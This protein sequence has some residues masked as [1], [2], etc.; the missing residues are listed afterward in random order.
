MNS[1]QLTRIYFAILLGV[2]TL[3]SNISKAQCDTIANVCQKSYSGSFISDGQQYRSLLINNEIAE[4]TTTFYG[5][6][7]YRIMACSGLSGG[8]LVFRLYDSERHLLFNS[9]DYRNTP[10]WDFKFT[11]TVNCTIEAQLANAMAG[12]TPDSTAAS[13]CAVVLIG[14]KN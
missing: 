7:T 14:F 9:G 13:G 10:Y 1:K 2:S 4:Y 3:Y 8:N 12:G 6:S 5:G 11:S